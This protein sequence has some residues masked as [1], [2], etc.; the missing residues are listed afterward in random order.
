MCVRPCQR[1]VLFLLLL[2]SDRSRWSHHR[3]EFRRLLVA[4]K[5]AWSRV[6]HCLWE[7]IISR[8][9][10]RPCHHRVFHRFNEWSHRLLRRSLL[11]AGRMK[12]R[13]N[14][15][16]RRARVQPPYSAR[17]SLLRT[18]TRI[19]RWEMNCWFCRCHSCTDWSHCFKSVCWPIFMMPSLSVCL[20]WIEGFRWKNRKTLILLFHTC[21]QYIVFISMRSIRINSQIIWCRKVAKFSTVGTAIEGSVF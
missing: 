20:L 11:E 21:L 16:R 12:R 13:S 1:A 19:Y 14:R 6:D 5:V 7:R 18:K 4:A 2:R 3:H 17:M 10:V 9:G 15:W 8:P